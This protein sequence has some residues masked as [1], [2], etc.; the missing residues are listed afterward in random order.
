MNITARYFNKKKGA[1]SLQAPPISCALAQ[2]TKINNLARKMR[3]L[4]GC[5]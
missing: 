4:S 5:D 3:A 1:A 2:G